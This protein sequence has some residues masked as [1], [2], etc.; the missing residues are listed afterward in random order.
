MD[1]AL[2]QSKDTIDAVLDKIFGDSISSS[3]TM[4]F[5]EQILSKDYGSKSTVAQKDAFKIASVLFSLY[6]HDFL[7]TL[8]RNFIP[9]VK[10]V[11]LNWAK[12]V[13]WTLS[14][15]SAHAQAQIREGKNKIAFFG[16][17]LLLQ[18]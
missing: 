5:L 2:F 13:L 9:K 14:Q 3:L 10:P 11:E 17:T 18:V 16:C 1:F 4:S 15:A 12:F 6:H 8:L 7:I